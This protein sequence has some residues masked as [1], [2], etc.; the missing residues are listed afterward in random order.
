M[1]IPLRVNLN[2]LHLKQD[3][4]RIFSVL[5]FQSPNC[6]HLLR[7]EGYKILILRRAG[8]VLYDHIDRLFG[9]ALLKVYDMYKINILEGLGWLEG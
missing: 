4:I 5:H 7:R 6:L 2:R 8:N 1:T 3:A 9:I